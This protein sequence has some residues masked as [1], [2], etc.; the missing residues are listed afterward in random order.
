VV[1]ARVSGAVEAALVRFRGGARFARSTAPFLRDG[2]IDERALEALHGALAS[3]PDPVAE[4]V[5][6]LVVDV[7]LA[8]DPQA[9]AGG[10]MIRDRRV[11]AVLAS[12][13]ARP[14][15][16][17]RIA[18]LD[19]LE[20]NVP[21]ALLGELEVRLVAE[22]AARPHATLF[23]LAAKGKLPSA[24]GLVRESAATPRW[25]RDEA[26][27]IARAAFGDA[28]AEGEFLR[29]FT[30]T[31]DARQKARFAAALG[32]VGSER[33]VVA[34]AR[35][36]RT[37]LVI[38][39]PNALERSVRLDVIQALSHVFPDVQLFY[40]PSITSDE[41]Y[42]AIEAWAEQSFRVTWSEPRPPFLTIAGY[43]G[44]RP[45]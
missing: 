31:T 16:P 18:C 28:G 39:I 29:P 26:A 23:L 25:E 40:F 27:A 37:P 8:V 34:L 32:K 33:A 15:G 11:I 2:A 7:G 22:L 9:W 24:V 41:S 17:G 35:A 13:L 14:H 44:R 42:A 5:A 3:E 21:G 36:L 12:G 6:R 45:S 30:A 43:P 4:S 20:R 1:G 38:D 19:G 10:T